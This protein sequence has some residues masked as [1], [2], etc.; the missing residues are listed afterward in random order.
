MKRFFSPLPLF[1]E[2]GLFAIRILV[3][4]FM[5]YHG[6]EVFDSEAMNGYLQWDMFKS[7]STGKLLVYLGKASELFGGVLLL[8]GLFTRI[9]LIILACTMT[10]IT[11]FVGHGKIWYEDQYPF[12]FVVLCFVFFFTGAG[13]YSFDNFLF[14]RKK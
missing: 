2:K 8:I 13:K 4:A 11:F 14:N 6:F 9:A 5:I 12:L 10:Y 1:Q 3:A 7:P